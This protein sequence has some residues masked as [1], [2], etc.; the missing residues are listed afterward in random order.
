[1]EG[2]VP[3]LQI[4]EAENGFIVAVQLCNPKF[5]ALLRKAKGNTFIPLFDEQPEDEGDAPV[6]GLI[7]APQPVIERLYV[8]PTWLELIAWLA[9]NKMG[10]QPIGGMYERETDDR[11]TQRP[12]C[13]GEADQEGQ[14]EPPPA[15]G[16][17]GVP[18]P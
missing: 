15:D 9:E 6:A 4:A 12:S 5:S 16:R 8:F 1:M 13:P 2:F 3:T 7:A 14:E 11:E 18:G 10:S 17:D